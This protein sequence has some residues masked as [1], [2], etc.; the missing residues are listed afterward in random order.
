MQS[1]WRLFSQTSAERLSR[2]TRRPKLFPTMVAGCTDLGRPQFS[3]SYSRFSHPVMVVILATPVIAL[4]FIGRNL[5][6]VEI[7]ARL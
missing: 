1:G 4:I 7:L 3:V 2:A 6:R 5:R